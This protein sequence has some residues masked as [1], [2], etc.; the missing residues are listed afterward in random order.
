M[1]KLLFATNIV[2]PRTKIHSICLQNIC[3][4]NMQI[5]CKPSKLQSQIYIKKIKATAVTF[6]YNA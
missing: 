1:I 2:I 5:F 4:N 3:M 6:I